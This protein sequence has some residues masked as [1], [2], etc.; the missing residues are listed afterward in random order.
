MSDYEKKSNNKGYRFLKVTGDIFVLNLEFIFT[1]ILS[2]TFLFFPALFSLAEVLKNE[3]HSYA[4]PFRDF[5]VLIKKHFRKGTIYWLI[6]LPL[7]A[8]FSYLLYL[9]YQLIQNQT[10]LLF[11][12]GSLILVI[13]IIIALTSAIMQLVNFVSYFE[14]SSAWTAFQK[15]S[16]IARK[17][18]LLV[19][20]TWMLVLSF[21]F[22]FYMFWPLIF[23]FGIG[24]MVYLS[25]CMSRNVYEKLRR[26]EDERLKKE[27]TK[28]KEDGKI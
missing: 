17:K 2:L 15:A 24:L 27:E 6:F 22:I 4:N 23:F 28:Q 20:S 16:L 12:W 25:V 8:L 14:E 9:D 7:Y 19:L 21:V 11:A 26:E 13:G 10:Q 1:V 18:F 5:F 3:K